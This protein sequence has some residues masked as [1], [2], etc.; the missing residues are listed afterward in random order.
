MAVHG[1]RPPGAAGSGGLSAVA[2]G[3]HLKGTGTDDDPIDLTD[4]EA[5]R[6][7]ALHDAMRERVGA[8][9]MTAAAVQDG[10]IPPATVGFGYR[11]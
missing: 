3:P 1:P 10:S 5:A 9:D 2:H 7:D 11:P 6:L 4:R 8:W